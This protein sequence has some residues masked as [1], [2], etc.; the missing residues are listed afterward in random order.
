MRPRECWS[1]RLRALCGRS[2]P[3]PLI[4]ESLCTTP[5]HGSLQLYV[6]VMVRGFVL[7]T[8]TPLQHPPHGSWFQAGQ[9]QDPPHA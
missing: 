6:P 5:P 7:E 2:C 3:P 8:N 9:E 1:L 4:S